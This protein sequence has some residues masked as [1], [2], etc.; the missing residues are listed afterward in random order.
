MCD[1]GGVCGAAT[2]ERAAVVARLGLADLTRAALPAGHREVRIWWFP[3]AERGGHLRRVFADSTGRSGA[4]EVDWWPAAD[5]IEGRRRAATCRS[6]ASVAGIDLCVTDS[7]SAPYAANR[8]ETL[9]KRG[10]W[11]LPG[12]ATPPDTALRCA[13]TCSSPERLVV[14][15]RD[16]LHYRTYGYGLPRSD[17]A[18]QSNAYSLLWAY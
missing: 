7:V 12:D 18:M 2:G 5:S 3:V 8:L 11:T 16:G 14:E 1:P 15:V 13:D 4:V 6:I 10:V 9:A 17:G